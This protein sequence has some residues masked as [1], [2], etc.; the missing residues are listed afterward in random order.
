MSDKTNFADV[1]R[2]NRLTLLA[3]LMLPVIGMAIAIPLI[4]WRVPG[5]ARVAIPIII[6]L[7]VQY[8]LLVVW[9]S[10]KMSQ[11]TSS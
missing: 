11:I 5:V 7:M 6:V 4:L 10:R 3:V 9:I 1:I 8:T 2:K